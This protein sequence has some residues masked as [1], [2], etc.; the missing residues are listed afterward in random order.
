MRACAIN[1][2][3]NE[4]LEARHEGRSEQHAHGPPEYSAHRETQ[5]IHREFDFEIMSTC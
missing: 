1:V 5:R 2:L 3:S 4:R